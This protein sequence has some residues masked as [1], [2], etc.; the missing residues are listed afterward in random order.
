MYSLTRQVGQLQTC[1]CGYGRVLEP[2]QLVEPEYC[3]MNDPASIYYHVNC[4]TDMDP[5]GRPIVSTDHRYLRF[6]LSQLPVSATSGQFHI[7]WCHL[8]CYWHIIVSYDSCYISR[9]VNYEKSFVQLTTGGSMC[10]NYVLPFIF[11]EKYQIS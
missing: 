2:A 9:A 1:S 4:V 8:C 5:N 7:F 11:S 10:S 3:S 6:S